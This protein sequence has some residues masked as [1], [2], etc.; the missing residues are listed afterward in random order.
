MGSHKK[1]LLQALTILVLNFCFGNP[2]I[3]TF[4]GQLVLI[5]ILS[6]I[7]YS[8]FSTVALVF[9]VSPHSNYMDQYLSKNIPFTA[10]YFIVYF[11][12]FYVAAVIFRNFMN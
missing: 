9:G 4:N 11:L 2:K 12:H 10:V 8:E 6:I 7:L 3:H 5:T 1:H